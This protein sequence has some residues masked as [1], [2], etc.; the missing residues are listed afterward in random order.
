MRRALA[1]FSWAA[2]TQVLE[3]GCGHGL[4][5]IFCASHGAAS[6]H[7]QVAVRRSS[8][9]PACGPNPNLQALLSYRA[10]REVRN[11]RWPLLAAASAH[12]SSQCVISHRR[13]SER[14][15]PSAEHAEY[16]LRS[17]L[18][19]SHVRTQST[20]IRTFRRVPSAEAAGAVALQHGGCTYVSACRTVLVPPS[21]EPL[22]RQD[23]NADVLLRLTIP[24]V[25]LSQR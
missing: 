8:L 4:P 22:E 25:Q 16:P 20:P 7:F 6:V 2:H 1:S 14:P 15:A 11:A 24:N 5:G 3:L 17:T 9:R 19:Y 18:Q 12:P 10:A 23:Y 21:V 13:A